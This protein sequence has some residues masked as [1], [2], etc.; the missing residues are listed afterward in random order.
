M[1]LSV[2][3]IINEETQS[4]MTPRGR[5]SYAQTLVKGKENEHGQVK[6]NCNLM[7]PPESD[8]KVLKKALMKIALKET[9]GDKDRALTFVNSRFLDP[10]NLP[11]GGQPAG[12]EFKG[13]TLLR[14]ASNH[15][16]D[17]IHPNGKPMTT[18][19]AI[20]EV[21]SGRW[22]RASCNPYWFV[23]KGNKG[24]T[25]GLQN[26]QLLEHDDNLGGGKPSGEGQFGKVSDEGSSEGTSDDTDGAV[27]S[28]DIDALFD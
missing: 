4:Y 18:D 12:P 21:Y 3:S 26:V 6:Y 8:F 15:R 5:L 20:N 9:D 23:A 11:S 13:W 24:V 22:A 16:P 10:N 1:D 14:M 19:E 7:F 27:S 25:I 2:A 28:D 17:F